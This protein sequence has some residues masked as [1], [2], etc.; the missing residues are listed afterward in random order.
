MISLAKD[1]TDMCAPETRTGLPLV[2]AEPSGCSCCSTSS[3]TL[4]S[5]AVQGSDYSVE[6]LTCGHC[7]QSVE[8]AVSGLDGV[9]SAAVELVPGGTSRLSVSGAHTDAE[10]R[11]AVAAAG[12]SLISR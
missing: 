12:Y 3:R 6:G 10:V 2:A 9:T 7:V 11:D 8:K 4:A 1:R 5:P